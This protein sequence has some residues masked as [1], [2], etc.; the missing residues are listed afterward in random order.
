MC[1]PVFVKMK[2]QSVTPIR[3]DC[4]LV[5]TGKRTVSGPRICFEKRGNV[6]VMQYRGAF[7]KQAVSIT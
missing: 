5:L 4:D 2:A 1:T 7:A 3:R 6:R